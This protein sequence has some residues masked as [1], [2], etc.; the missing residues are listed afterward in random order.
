MIRKVKYQMLKLDELS[1]IGD[2]IDSQYI[3]LTGRGYLPLGA[4]VNKG[5]DPLH[6]I[7]VTLRIPVIFVGK[8]MAR[9]WLFCHDIRKKLGQ[10]KITIRKS[11]ITIRK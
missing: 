3:H 5:D 1:R 8:R 10:S 4:D 9:N 11:K 6:D 7:K 2:T